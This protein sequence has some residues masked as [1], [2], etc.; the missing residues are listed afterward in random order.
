LWANAVFLLLTWAN[1]VFLLLAKA[2]NPPPCQY[3]DVTAG[4]LLGL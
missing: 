4:A 1:A 3:P 2:S